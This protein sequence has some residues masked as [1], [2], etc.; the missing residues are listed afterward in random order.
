VSGSCGKTSRRRL[1]PCKSFPI[2]VSTMAAM[3][4]GGSCVANVASPPQCPPW[5][6]SGQRDKQRASRRALR[7]KIERI[8]K[9]VPSKPL[10]LANN[11]N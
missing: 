6:G 1:R 11:H 2:V 8:P 7:S 9:I 10:A 5:G 3:G 4:L